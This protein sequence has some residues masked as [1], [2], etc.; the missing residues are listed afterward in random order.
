MKTIFLIT[1]LTTLVLA[2]CSDSSTVITNANG[3][4]ECSTQAKAFVDSYQYGVA[5]LDY[6]YENHY[7]NKF[8]KCYISMWASGPVWAD[9]VLWD[10]YENKLISQCEFYTDSPTMNFCGF[11]NS[12]WEDNLEWYNIDKFNKFIKTYME[13]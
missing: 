12:N 7:S 13:W 11:P 6:K 10:V 3:P 2:G 4:A 5:D 8:N 1:I 9:N